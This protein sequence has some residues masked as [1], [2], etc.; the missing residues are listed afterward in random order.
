MA[1]VSDDFESLLITKEIGDSYQ[2][3]LEENVRL[4]WRFLDKPNVVGSFE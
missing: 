4:T 1:F 3:F 2:K